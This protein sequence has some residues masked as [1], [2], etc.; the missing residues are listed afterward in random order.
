MLQKIR[1][2]LGFGK[3]VE[4]KTH[5]AL[6]QLSDADLE[7]TSNVIEGVVGE[8]FNE[9]LSKVHVLE[10]D[11]DG[12]AT[13]FQQ[14]SDDEVVDIHKGIHETRKFSAWLRGELNMRQASRKQKGK[15]GKKNA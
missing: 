11:A 14:F 7:T 6:A 2:R 15:K 3:Q 5:P 10:I 4:V 1:D 13:S 8:Y 9:R 12:V